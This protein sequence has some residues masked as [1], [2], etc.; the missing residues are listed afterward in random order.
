M[1]PIYNSTIFIFNKLMWATLEWEL[2]VVIRYRWNRMNVNIHHENVKQGWDNPCFHFLNLLL[3]KALGRG[4]EWA[5]LTSW[6]E[7]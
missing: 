1:R 7:F 2:F 4:G 3:G 5:T 6:I